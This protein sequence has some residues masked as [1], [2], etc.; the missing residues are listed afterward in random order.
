MLRKVLENYVKKTK[1]SNFKFH[2]SITSMLLF[3]FAWSKLFALLRSIKIISI[4]KLRKKVFLGKSVTFFNKKNIKLGNNVNIGDF[5]KIYALGEKPLV[6]GNNVNIGSFSQVV[7]STTFNMPGKFIIIGN[8]VGIG[9]FSYLGGAGGLE[10]GEN[11]IIGQYFSAHP[12]NHN[13]SNQDILIR[14]Q[15]VSRKGIVIGSNCWIGSKVTVLDGVKI[16]NNCV[17]AAGSVVTKPTPD[18]VLVAGVP[19]KVIKDLDAT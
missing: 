15:G 1:N 3:S 16:G 8:N 7:I 17:I 6:I 2:E 9:E 11:T 5:V 19:A 10:I 14:E 18:N 13:Y 4:T 12:E